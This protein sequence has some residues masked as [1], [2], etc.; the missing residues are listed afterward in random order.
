MEI[1]E[2][3]VYQLIEDNMGYCPECNE[4]LDAFFEPDAENCP[5]YNCGGNKAMGM[6]NAVLEELV[7]L[8]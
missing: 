2:E 8:G 6:E 5:C 7:I 4:V 1:P 3:E